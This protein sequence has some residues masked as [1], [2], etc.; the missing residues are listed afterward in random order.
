MDERIEKLIE[1]LKR[2][3]DT[4]DEMCVDAEGL[5]LAY[6]SDAF[7]DIDSAIDSLGGV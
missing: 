3:R 5:Q 7:D 1:T 6:L 4:V 2:V